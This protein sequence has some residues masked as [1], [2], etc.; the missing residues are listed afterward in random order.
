MRL[1]TIIALALS[2]LALPAIDVEPDE[3]LKDP[4]MEARARAI[5]KNLRCL[6]CQNENIDDSNAGLA[7]DLRI[8]LRERLMAGDTDDQAVSF[9]VDRF[10]EFVLLKPRFA[11]HTLVLWLGPFVLLAFGIFS[12]WR[13]QSKRNSVAVAEN[14]LSLDEQNRLKELLDDKQ[15]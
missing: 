7:K 6:V 3:M 13:I 2:I 14:E 4:K 15:S 11:A 10:G 8:K 5:S 12:L 9:L 1:L